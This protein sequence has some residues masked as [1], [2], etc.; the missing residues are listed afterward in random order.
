MTQDDKMLTRQEAATYLGISVPSLARWA[1]NAYGPAY[2]KLR[3]RTQYRLSD[4]DAFIRSRRREVE[5]Q[6]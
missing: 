4:L 5:A 1:C 6:V 3:G 2:Y